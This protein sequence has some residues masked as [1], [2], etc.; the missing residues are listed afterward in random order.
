MLKIPPVVSKRK[1][2]RRKSIIHQTDIIFIS[3][4]APLPESAV[5]TIGLIRRRTD[6]GGLQSASFPGENIVF[7]DF[8]PVFRTFGRFS[9]RFRKMFDRNRLFLQLLHQKR[10]SFE[11][12]CI[13]MKEKIRGEEIPMENIGHTN[14]NIIRN[15]IGL[16]ELLA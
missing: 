13:E 8:G 5:N 4:L 7:S 15:L 1:N 6:V 3:V 10:A 2:K 9:V 16:Q 11:N 12:Y 14:P